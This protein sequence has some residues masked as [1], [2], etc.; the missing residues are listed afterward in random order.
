MTTYR[1]WRRRTVHYCPLEPPWSYPDVLAGAV[2]VLVTGHTEPGQRVLLAE[3]LGDHHDEIVEAILRLG[4]GATTISNASHS[5]SA[6][7]ATCDLIICP[8]TATAQIAQ[9]AQRL[10]PAGTLIILTTT[11]GA[12]HPHET[13]TARSRTPHSAAAPHW[14]G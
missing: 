8:R 4:R 2:S 6:N 7:G 9:W 5:G 11:R 3:P 10:T 1:R 14:P 13:A 12:R